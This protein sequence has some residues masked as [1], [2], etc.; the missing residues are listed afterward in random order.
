MSDQVE[1][2]YAGNQET[3]I[4]I[5]PTF[6]L[7]ENVRT[8]I[9]NTSN[10][11][12]HEKRPVICLGYKS[13]KPV[14]LSEQQLILIT[15]FYFKLNCCFKEKGVINHCTSDIGFKRNIDTLSVICWEIRRARDRKRNNPPLF[16]LF[17]FFSFFL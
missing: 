13:S 12:N 5:S 16:V 11:R 10:P 15:D 8:S 9:T 17:P 2:K 14:P 7:L 4:L 6:F 3:K 1:T